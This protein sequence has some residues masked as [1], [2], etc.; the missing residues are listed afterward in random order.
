MPETNAHIL[1]DEFR[2][3]H[4]HFQASITQVCQDD[5]IDAFHLTLLGEDLEEFE[6]A[7]SQNPAIFPDHSE[8]EVLQTNVQSM[9]I[10][11]RTIYRLR[12]EQS[13]RGHP[14]AI[15]RE[16]TG[17]VGRPRIIIDPNFLRWA[18]GR[19]TTSGIAYFLNVSRRTVR[20]SL[21]EYGIVSPGPNL[22]QS[23]SSS[24]YLSNMSDN[25]LDTMI[26]LLRSHYPGAGI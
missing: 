26:Q 21:L 19:R 10:D 14:N 17:S 23:S 5:T 1:L 12:V 3:H 2:R 13:H 20:R 15:S 22:I 9:I 7:V 18:Y 25:D 8:W 24:T 11:L 4:L 16:H 6:N